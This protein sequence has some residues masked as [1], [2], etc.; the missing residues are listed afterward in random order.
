M[1]KLVVRDG[2]RGGDLVLVENFA[3]SD[4]SDPLL[5]RFRDADEPGGCEEILATLI[6]AAVGDVVDEPREASAA[7]AGRRSSRWTWRG[8]SGEAA[9]R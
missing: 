9:D 1:A 7:G 8:T 2:D 5:A 3:H 6:E 4:G